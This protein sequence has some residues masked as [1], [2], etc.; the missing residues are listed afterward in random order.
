MEK[1]GHNL[2][3]PTIHNP[4]IMPILI[5][6]LLISAHMHIYTYPPLS[7]PVTHVS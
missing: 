1:L 2:P 7:Y 3:S 6:S 4:L 5:P